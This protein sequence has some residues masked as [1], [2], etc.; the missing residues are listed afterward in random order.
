MAVLLFKEEIELNRPFYIGQ[1]VLD[2]SKLRMYQLQ[3]QQSQDYMERFYCEIE[4]VAR[5][6]DSF[7]SEMS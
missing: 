6:T 2:I 5:D 7:S 1:S 3:Y 4:I